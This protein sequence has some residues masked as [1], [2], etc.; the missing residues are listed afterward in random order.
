M[1]KIKIRRID[2]KEFASMGHIW[3][4]VCEHDY[5]SIFQTFE[6]ACNWWKTYYRH[7]ELLVL[8]VTDGDI[9]VAIAPLVITKEPFNR[10]PARKVEF[11]CR[12]NLIIRSGKEE[13]IGKLLDY[14]RCIQ[15]SWDVIDFSDMEHDLEIIDLLE[16][17]AKKS[18]FSF[19]IKDD[20]PYPYINMNTSWEEYWAKRSKSFKGNLRYSHKLME[21]MGDMGVNIKIYDSLHSQEMKKA[22]DK[23]FALSLKSWQ[24]KAG[25]AAG[26]SKE[27]MD[28]YHGLMEIFSKK[29]KVEISFLE[30][31]GIPVSFSMGIIY[32]DM[33]YPFKMGYDEEYAKMSP[34]NILTYSVLQKLF[35]NGVM[36]MEWLRGMFPQKRIWLTGIDSRAHVVIFKRS[37]PSRILKFSET[38]VRQWIKMIRPHKK[39]N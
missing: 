32:G 38:R 2:N 11:M 34:G 29:G 18:G 20:H 3:E 5:A 17:E 12:M 1:G 7:K 19:L 14:L 24:A 31:K 37:L 8:L 35:N 27:A 23:A 36:R 6:W 10:L 26:S 9:P 15:G 39:D 28:F 25:I 22:I 4:E 21:R 13:V 16:E 33:Y 30:H